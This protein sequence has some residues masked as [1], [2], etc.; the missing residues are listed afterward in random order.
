ML[1][2]GCRGFFTAFKMARLRGVI[3]VARGGIKARKLFFYFKTEE[4]KNRSPF[5][6]CEA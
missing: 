6:Y 2:I 1:F 3:N 4:Q 5:C